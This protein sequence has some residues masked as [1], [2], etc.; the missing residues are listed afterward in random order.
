MDS[1]ETIIS[2]IIGAEQ[3]EG[4]EI[5]VNEESKSGSGGGGYCVIA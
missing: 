1:F 5:P 4:A 2:Q 3:V